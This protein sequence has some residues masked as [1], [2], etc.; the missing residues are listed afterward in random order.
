MTFLMFLVALS[1]PPQTRADPGER[2]FQ[3]CSG[4]HSLRPGDA[5]AI[6]PSL[7]G[8][9][10]RRAGA[11]EGFAYS[12]AMRAAGRRR[13]VWDAATLERFLVDPEGVVPGT[14]MPNQGGPPVERAALID[15]LRR[16]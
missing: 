12:D 3:R 6:A 7:H 2:A 8:V 5:D 13:L 4:C 9:I 11:V 1:A 14:S 16:R 10:G 15:W